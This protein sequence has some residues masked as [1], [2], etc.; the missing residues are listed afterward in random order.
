MFEC[1]QKIR[2]NKYHANKENN[3]TNIYYLEFKKKKKKVHTL[4]KLIF[5]YKR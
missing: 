3:N 1:G 2:Y 4:A 5:N